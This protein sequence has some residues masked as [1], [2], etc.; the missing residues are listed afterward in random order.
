MFR[1][2]NLLDNQ[3]KKTQVW[4]NFFATRLPI[5]PRF[6][7]ARSVLSGME[8]GSGGSL[9]ALQEGPMLVGR[10]VDVSGENTCEIH[11][12]PHYLPIQEPEGDE[13]PR[14]GVVTATW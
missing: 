2:Q 11:F 9:Q 10:Q 7:S 3:K 6:F 5:S 12:S 14:G 8:A 4:H 1:S 13:L